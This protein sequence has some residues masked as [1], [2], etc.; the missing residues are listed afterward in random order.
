MKRRLQAAQGKNLEDS[1]VVKN[2]I[3]IFKERQTDIY[4]KLT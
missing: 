2:D 3:S 4:Q 1:E